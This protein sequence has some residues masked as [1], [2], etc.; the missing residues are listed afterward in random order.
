[1]DISQ[2]IITTLAV[3]SANASSMVAALETKTGSG[4]R[5]SVMTPVRVG[6]SSGTSFSRVQLWIISGYMP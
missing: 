3:G 4:R 6:F 5:I 2:C 1:M